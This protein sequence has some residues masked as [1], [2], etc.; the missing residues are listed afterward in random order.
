MAVRN[1]GTLP[2]RGLSLVL[3]NPE[4]AAPATDANMR[5]PIKEVL[6]GKKP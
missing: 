4:V 1:V 6:A 3:D 2:A 5:R